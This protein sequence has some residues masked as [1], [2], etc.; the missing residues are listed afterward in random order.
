MANNVTLKIDG[1]SMGEII[2][3]NDIPTWTIRGAVV[4]EKKPI[5]N[6]KKT[7]VDVKDFGTD[8]IIA[9]IDIDN[10]TY[11][12]RIEIMQRLQDLK[13][14][15]KGEHVTVEFSQTCASGIKTLTFNDCLCVDIDVK[16]ITDGAGGTFTFKFIYGN[17]NMKINQIKNGRFLVP[18]G[19]TSSE[20]KNWIGATT[21]GNSIAKRIKDN[22]GNF[23]YLLYADGSNGTEVHT[24]AATDSDASSDYIGV[25]NV[26][27]ERIDAQEDFY[28]SAAWDQTTDVDN[29]LTF[30]L[31]IY[32]GSPS[33]YSDTFT[34][35]KNTK[36]TVFK[37]AWELAASSNY[38]CKISIASGQTG[39]LLIKR[40]WLE[41]RKSDEC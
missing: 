27:L 13:E 10:A 4:P 26:E 21:G 40:A 37:T 18:N 2:G 39:G 11:A 24:F 3:L 12:Y 35:T 30:T 38:A 36:Q 28:T 19:T 22:N 33:I 34:I 20:A 14:L 17:T 31:A 7:A 9:D 8:M 25:F 15:Y 16:K 41:T 29:E 1:V 23:A 6:S 5:A 32:L